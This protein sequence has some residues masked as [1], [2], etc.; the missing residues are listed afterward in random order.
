MQQH[1]V[2]MWKP[3]LDVSLSFLTTWSSGIMYFYDYFQY[4]IQLHYP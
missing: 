3:I 2:L 4:Y 1:K